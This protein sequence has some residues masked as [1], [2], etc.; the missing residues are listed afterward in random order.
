MPSSQIIHRKTRSVKLDKTRVVS[1][2]LTNRK[3]IMNHLRSNMDIRETEMTM[4][5]THRSD[6]ET[7]TI[8]DHDGRR[9]RGEDAIQK[10]GYPHQ[11]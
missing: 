9:T 8:T 6:R 4:S 11:E 3:E 2:K 1:C 10:K 7:R 5:R